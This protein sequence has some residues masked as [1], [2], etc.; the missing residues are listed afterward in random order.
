[1]KKQFYSSPELNVKYYGT[2]D[3]L[4]SSGGNALEQTDG[5]VLVSPWETWI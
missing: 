5:G 4:V 2:E 3:I 1:M